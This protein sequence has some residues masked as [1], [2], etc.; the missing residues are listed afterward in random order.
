MDP[1]FKLQELIPMNK[2]KEGKRVFFWKKT[3]TN[4]F[5]RKT[6]LQAS[7]NQIYPNMKVR[8]LNPKSKKAKRT[9]SF[10]PSEKKAS[11]CVEASL[12]FSFFLFFFMNIFSIILSFVLYT[13]DFTTLQQQGKEK[14]AY[15]Y[16]T[17]EIWK[18]NEALIVLKKERQISSPFSILSLPKYRIEAKCVVK[19]WVGYDITKGK[20]RREEETLVYITEYGSVYHRKRSCTYLSLSIQVVSM[21]N[22]FQKKNQAGENYLPCEYCGNNFYSSAVYVTAYGNKYHTS[23]NCRGLKRT[24]KVIPLA[25]VEGRTA[26]KKCG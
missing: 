3:V 24:V 8:L 1:V 14:S 15:A 16:L 21:S 4:I 23:M 18:E 6:S 10:S 12:T 5:C 20:E 9:L 2:R 11:I 25:E 7:R 13:K 22:V 26:C 17:K 19:P